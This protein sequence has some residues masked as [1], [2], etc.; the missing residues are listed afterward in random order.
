MRTEASGRREARRAIWKTEREEDE[1][2]IEVKEVDIGNIKEVR[3]RT[4]LVLVPFEV[5]LQLSCSM[6]N[7]NRC[8]GKSL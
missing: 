3:T 6:E 2:G 1:V 8:G 7:H 5:E 4:V